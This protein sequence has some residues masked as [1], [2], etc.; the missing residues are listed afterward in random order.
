MV[1]A[2]KKEGAFQSKIG[3]QCRGQQ[4]GKPQAVKQVA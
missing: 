4:E 1:Q 2:G 3:K